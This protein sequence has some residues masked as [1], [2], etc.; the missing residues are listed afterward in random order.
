MAFGSTE[1]SMAVRRSVLGLAGVL[2]VSLVASM[3]GCSSSESSGA[4]PTPVSDAGPP[5][6]ANDGSVSAAQTLPPLAALDALSLS[7]GDLSP[8]FS[9]DVLDY[10]ISSLNTLLAFDVLTKAA[11]GLVV[12]VNGSPATSGVA[13]SVKL[14]APQDIHVSVTSASGESRMYT[15]RYFRP[16]LPPYTVTNAVPA[17]AGSEN[18]MLTPMNGWLMIVDRAGAPLYYRTPPATPAGGTAKTITDFRRHTVTGGQVLYSY[19]A[20]NEGIH[21]LDDHFRELTTIPVL[22]NKDHGIAPTDLHDF[23]VLGP[24][25]YL[26]MAYVLKV[27]DLSGENAAWSDEAQVVAAVIQEIDHGQVLFEWDS[28]DVPSLFHDSVYNNPFT[29]S[30]VS[31][32]V[33]AN[34]L[35]IDPA[36]GNVILS[37]RHTSSIVKISRTTGAILWTLGGKSDDFGLAPEQLTGFQ[38]HANKQADGSLLVFDNGT[39][40][41]GIGHATRVVEYVLDETNKTLTSFHE[42][43]TRPSGQP[44]TT[45]MGSAFRFAGDRY[46][47]GWGGRAVNTAGWP[48]V[49]EVVAGSVVWSLTFTTPSTFSYR[50]HPMQ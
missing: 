34:S 8:A 10:T 24:E 42:V 36:D 49:S 9:P 33:H 14:A 5:D 7:T 37:M 50:A 2:A 47:V 46:L 3:V 16:D 32:Y 30:D 45:F 6:A 39:Y 29:A 22:A 4:Q 19:G 44:D 20:S 1:G 27:K 23:L 21:L 28:D 15:V 12:T 31:D 17:L 48:A 18:I 40:A 41:P 43:Y 26:V 25:H 35:Q 11:D 38:H 13:A